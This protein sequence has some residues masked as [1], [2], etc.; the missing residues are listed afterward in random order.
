[1]IFRR[2]DVVATGDIFTTG[3]NANGIQAY[4][5][6]AGPAAVTSTG[7]ITTKGDNS[8]GINANGFSG[9]PITS[10]GSI[11]TSGVQAYGIFANRT[12]GGTTVERRDRDQ[13]RWFARHQ[14]DQ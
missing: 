4:A 12:N 13:W 9:S 6:F 1:M 8:F 3:V 2:S 5:Y 11:S 7:N 10:I 14:C